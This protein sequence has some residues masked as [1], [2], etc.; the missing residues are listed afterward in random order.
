MMTTTLDD[1]VRSIQ[2]KFSEGSM[3]LSNVKEN[4]TENQIRTFANAVALFTTKPVI[5]FIIH[6]KKSAGLV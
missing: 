3:T 1:G 2:L 6:D 4:V 5:S